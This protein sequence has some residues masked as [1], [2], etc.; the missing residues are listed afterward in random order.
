MRDIDEGLESDNEDEENADAVVTNAAV[1]GQTNSIESPDHLTSDESYFNNVDSSKW[2]LEFKAML[3]SQKSLDDIAQSAL[4]VMELL[5]L[6]KI[7]KGSLSMESKYKSLSARW[8]GCKK[9]TVDGERGENDAERRTYIGRD[10][11]VRFRV[12]RGSTET[13]EY[14]RVLGLFSKHYGKW[15]LHWDDGEVEFNGES[16]KYKLICRMVGKDGNNSF[17][18]INLVKN[19]DWN[20]KCVFTIR[21]MSEVVGVEGVLDAGSS[22]Q[23]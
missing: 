21:Y 14:F 23:W 4:K 7:E 5:Q 8:F 6:G 19:G 2:F 13:I 9:S 16:K 10:T 11:L 3:D 15:H 20:T 17:K 22:S 12:K 18:E 1:T